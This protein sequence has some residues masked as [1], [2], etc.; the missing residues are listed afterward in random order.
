MGIPSDIWAML[1]WQLG[2]YDRERPN[3]A[4]STID[5]RSESNGDIYLY[6]SSTSAAPP[7]SIY[8]SWSLYILC[9]RRSRRCLTC[10]ADLGHISI[11]DARRCFGCVELLYTC[12]SIY[13]NVPRPLFVQSLLLSLCTDIFGDQSLLI[14]VGPLGNVLS[15]GHLSVLH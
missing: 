9:I 3:V 5:D 4:I 13:P 2:G 8:G 11:S 12:T 6:T 7:A 15:D 1:W 14:T 10:S